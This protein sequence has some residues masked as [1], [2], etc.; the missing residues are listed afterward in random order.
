MIKR[1]IK[2]TL[3]KG[4]KQRRS[5]KVSWPVMKMTR[6][7]RK[8]RREDKN[9]KM[10]ELAKS[11][12]SQKQIA[13][14]FSMTKVTVQRRI[15]NFYR[16]H[17]LPAPKPRGRKRP[18]KVKKKPELITSFDYNKT[19]KRLIDSRTIHNIEGIYQARSILKCLEVCPF[20]DVTAEFLKKSKS[21]TYNKLRYYLT[22]D[23][24]QLLLKNLKGR[25]KINSKSDCIKDLEKSKI[26]ISLPLKKAKVKKVKISRTPTDAQ[27]EQIKFA[28]ARIA[29]AKG[30]AFTTDKSKIWDIQKECEREIRY[31][32]KGID[33]EPV[34]YKSKADSRY[35]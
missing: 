24:F 31:L 12:K 33:I 25:R 4:R 17:D 10:Y 11:G 32:K 6:T 34:K 1:E 8:Q 22:E 20:V 5:G 13:E 14:E 26:K 16:K 21:A 18:I 3:K 2:M 28:E 30:R 27:K 23:E 9:R 19:R 29:R 35:Y 7:Q 15:T